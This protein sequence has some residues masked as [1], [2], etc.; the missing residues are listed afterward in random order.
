MNIYGDVTTN[1]RIPHQK[2]VV[3]AIMNIVRAI[4]HE[5]KMHQ[6]ISSY[7]MVI[8]INYG[9]LRFLH[10]AGLTL[11]AATLRSV[12]VWQWQYAGEYY[13]GVM[14]FISYHRSILP[15]ADFLGTWSEYINDVH[16]SLRTLLCIQYGK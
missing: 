10:R 1:I 9:P 3:S 11:L 7:F 16:F 2:S 14:V 8:S 12:Y 15:S 4:M 5:Y 13:S 6:L